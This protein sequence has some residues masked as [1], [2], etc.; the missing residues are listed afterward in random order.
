VDPR[1]RRRAHLGVIGPLGKGGGG[2]GGASSPSSGGGG[3]GPGS[4]PSGGSGVV[5]TC[6]GRGRAGLTQALSAAQLI[7]T[8]HQSGL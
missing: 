7:A 2:G 3:G 4:A 8:S 6:P 1:N 5:S